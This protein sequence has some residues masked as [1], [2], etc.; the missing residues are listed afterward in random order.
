MKPSS[1][2]VVAKEESPPSPQD[3]K[4]KRSVNQQPSTAS[5]RAAQSRQQS[6][7]KLFSTQNRPTGDLSLAGDLPPDRK[8]SRQVSVESELA[9]SGSPYSLPREKM[10]SFTTKPING[11]VVDL[12]KSLP[13]NGQLR[14]LSIVKPVRTG[15]NAH[16]GAKKLVVKNLRKEP[17]WDGD[18]YFDQ[19]W[20]QLDS[21]LSRI[22]ADS[23]VSFSMEDLYRGV[24]SLCR[25]GKA[26][27]INTKLNERCV[28]HFR[29]HVQGSLLA[30]SAQENVSVLKAVLEAWSAWN[31]QITLIRCIFYYMDRS[32]L[33]QSSKTSLND[34]CVQIFRDQIFNNQ[35]LQPKIIDGA[36]DLIAAD[37]MAQD[38]DRAVLRQA[39]SMFHDL[40]V[41]G[42]KF[43]PRILAVTQ[44]YVVEL[45]DRLTAEKILPDY[46]ATVV[47]FM[48]KEVERCE[49]FGLDATTRKELLYLLEEHLVAQKVD[50]LTADAEVAELLDQNSVND[51]AQLFT[52]LQRRRLGA[53]LRTAFSQWVDDTGTIII[54]DDKAQ[55][56]MV[57]RLLSLKRRLDNIWMTAFDR[58]D[59]LG[60]GLR[61]SFEVFIN[62]T[63][64]GE[65]TWGT[66]NSKPGEMIAK[67]V[68]ILLRGGAKAI[69]AQLTVTN[70]DN[71]AN[72]QEEEDDHGVD[73]DTEVNSQLDQVLDLFRFVHGKA[74]FEAFYKKDLA[75]RLLMG[76]SASADAERSM[77]SRLK[78]ECGAGFTQNL[79]QM[80]KDVELGR[81]EMSSYK[82]R[83]E[84]RGERGQLDLNVNVLSAAAWPTY[85]DVPVII[86]AD[87]NRAIESFERHY[88]SKH[89]G[90]KLAWKHALAHCQM[91]AAFPKGTKEFVVSS[92]QAIVLL[93]FNGIGKEEHLTYEYIKT[94]SGL[95]KHPSSF[96]NTATNPLCS[97]SRS[98]ANP[99]ITRSRQNP[100]TEQA[101]P[102]QRHQRDRHVHNQ[103][104]LFPP[105]V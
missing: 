61:E 91:K 82:D 72:E 35:I 100:T 102:Q 93:L 52:L 87:V 49:V 55:D 31:A 12:T 59:Q 89:S 98:K 26:A 56:E 36:C 6:I 21:A 29:D 7:S 101:P 77:L 78:T 99:A 64:K 65:S 11:D 23:K 86:P 94:A 76:R 97:R 63:K 19:V 104:S 53:K 17:A 69:P 43:E 24:E 105:K 25:Q 10:Y 75:R 68:D 8:R 46:V 20:A 42:S 32:Y 50:Y 84:E 57:V 81:E 79:E 30:K 27:T 60:H 22:F 14:R 58:Q 1:S 4:R 2:S 92:F 9:H 62:K 41:Y 70:R 28:G 80:F 51:L 5:D 18:K 67:Y 45:G 90:R 38:L 15:L 48:S 34:V 88:K 54:F 40:A 66:D 85:P 16:A 37:R 95:C 103:R 74:V 73:E 3:R 44:T 47:D 39:I 33:L 71:T 96:S 13:Q 83:L